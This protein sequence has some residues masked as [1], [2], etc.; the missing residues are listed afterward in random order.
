[1]NEYLNLNAR[2]LVIEFLRYIFPY[3]QEQSSPA[4]SVQHDAVGNW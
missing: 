1:M 2:C 3:A 4:P